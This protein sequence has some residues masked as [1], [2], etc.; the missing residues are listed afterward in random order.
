METFATSE[1]KTWFNFFAVARK[2][3]NTNPSSLNAG[4]KTTQEKK[5]LGGGGG[6]GWGGGVGDKLSLVGK[7]KSHLFQ[8][9][10]NL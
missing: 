1:M 3:I 9:G 10:W 7:R 4:V 2:R 6:G 5:G 8:Q